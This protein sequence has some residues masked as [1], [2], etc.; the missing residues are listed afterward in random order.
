M[1]SPFS[2]FIK[3]LI[4]SEQETTDFSSVFEYTFCVM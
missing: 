2:H 4:T 3:V 1:Q